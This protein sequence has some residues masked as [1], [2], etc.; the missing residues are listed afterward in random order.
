MGTVWK[1]WKQLIMS[2]QKIE[3]LLNSLREVLESGKEVDVAEVPFIKFTGDIGGKGLL[4]IG[5][6]HTKQIVFSPKPDRFFVSENLDI[7]KEKSVSIN[8][9]KVLDEKELGN[10]VVKSNLREVGRLKGL[11]VDGGISINQYLFYDA[12]TD[13]LGLGTDQPKAAI[14]VV[15]QNIEIVLGASDPNVASIG[16]FNS[17]DLELVTDNT[18]R[19]TIEAGGN[20]TLGNP[21]TGPVKVSVMGSLG[22][23]VNSIDPR[24]NLHVSGAIKFNDK[25]HLSGNKP[26]EGGVFTEG[27]VIWNTDPQPGKFVGWVCTRAGNPGLWSGFGRI[28]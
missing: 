1:N 15:D 9:L 14:S 12:N 19:L 8:G 2:D 25:I 18:A 27:D 11:I 26:P 21:T 13:R 24:A 23:N 20:I 6:G 7:A 5:E 3:T 17:A 16:V 4:W 10:S 22:I 28:E